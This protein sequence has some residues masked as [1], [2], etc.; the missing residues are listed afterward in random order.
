M[1]G[2]YNATT[3]SRSG[4]VCN[5]VANVG[6][7]PLSR[8][9]ANI[10]PIQAG[11]GDPSPSNPRAI[12]GVSEVVTHNNGSSINQWDEQW[13]LGS[14]NWNTGVKINA[15]NLIRSK[16]KILLIG[17]Q[18]YYF[19]VG[20]PYN[21]FS[22]SLGGSFINALYKATDGIFTPTND[23]YIAFSVQN[24]TT[25]DNDISI[26]YPST[27]TLYHAYTGQTATINL[28][29]TYYGGSLNVGTGVLTVTHA[30]IASYNGESINEPWLCSEAPYIPNTTPPT[31]SQVVY[32]LTTPQTYQLTPAQLTQLLGENNVWCDCGDSEVDFFKIIRT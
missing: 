29:G 12:S 19:K 13:E 21:I 22:F 30:N 24:S 9:I 23:L 18:T 28:G 31:G 15:N 6:G 25:Y 20:K 3:M 2:T 14:Y 11:S 10:T 5:Y 32:P 27:D 26:N 16:N 7:V 4:A 17:G 8:F 1:N